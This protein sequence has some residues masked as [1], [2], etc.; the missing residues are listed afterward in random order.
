[1][2]ANPY[3]STSSQTYSEFGLQ[4]SKMWLPNTLCMTI[5]GANTAKTAIL[6][7]EACFPDS[8]VGF[9]PDETKSDLHFV[10]Y[11]LDLMRLRFLA[12]SRGA[13]Q[14]NLSLDKLLSFPILAPEVVEQRRIGAILSTYDDLIEVNRRRIALLEEMA[15]QLFGEWFVHLHFPGN[16]ANQ[17]V[18]DPF[19][20]CPEGWRRTTLGASF[21]VVLGGTPSRKR[22]DFWQD[23]DVPWIS[24]S[25]ANELRIAEP[26]EYITQ[27]ALRQSAAKMMPAGA[28][29][30]AITGATLG[31]VSVLLR[32]MCG[33]QS[34]VGLW[35]PN[36]ARREHV[37]RFVVH[38]LDRLVR[39]A[40]GG[41]QQHINKEIVERFPYLDP[42]PQ[43]LEQYNSLA[44]PLAD[45]IGLLVR[46]NF[47]LAASRDL[48]LPRL[49]SGELLVATAERDLEAAA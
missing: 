45:Q 42:P 23:G 6:K 16:E 35:D 8:V 5:A 27:G 40:S 37:Y 41:A 4:Q 14:D 22:D 24:S 32:P 26:S 28:V 7:I 18:P 13:T 10:K 2:A 1:M 39:H 17:P 25:K 44:L 46:Q 47:R 30:I 48:L 43:I 49:I 12:V 21:T 38:N 20:H 9:V 19:T 15:R 36:G 31:Q 3:I 34:L 33:N 11:S 29:V